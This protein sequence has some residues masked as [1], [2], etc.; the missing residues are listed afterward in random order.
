M[1]NVLNYRRLSLVVEARDAN[2]HRAHDCHV[3]YRHVTCS[4]HVIGQGPDSLICVRGH[5][6]AGG[7]SVNWSNN[8]CLDPPAHFANY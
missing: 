1:E 4:D 8:C 6:I 7:W 5:V 3:V 2:E